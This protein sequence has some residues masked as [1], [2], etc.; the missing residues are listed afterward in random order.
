MAASTVDGTS[1]ASSIC[2][3]MTLRSCDTMTLASVVLSSRAVMAVTLESSHPVCDNGVCSVIFAT[4]SLFSTLKVWRVAAK[5]TKKEERK[6]RRNYTQ[7]DVRP[8]V[9]SMTVSTPGFEA[10]TVEV[11]IPMTRPAKVAAK[12]TNNGKY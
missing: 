12:G 11:P 2:P 6:K 8:P 10:V 4:V 7:V 3:A 1:L 5:G 9:A